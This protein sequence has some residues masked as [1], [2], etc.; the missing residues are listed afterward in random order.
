MS[1]ALPPSTFVFSAAL[2]FLVGWYWTV[3]PVHL[4]NCFTALMW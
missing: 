4:S 2:E 1:G 3:I